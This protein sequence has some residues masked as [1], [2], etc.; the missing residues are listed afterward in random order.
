MLT[1]FPGFLVFKYCRT[2]SKVKQSLSS[3]A[4]ALSL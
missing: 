2:A 1:S 4:H 3:I